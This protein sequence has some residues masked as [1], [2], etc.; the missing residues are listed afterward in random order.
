MFC[1]A[2][3]FGVV[4]SSSDSFLAIHLHLRHHEPVTHG[5]VVAAVISMWLL[6]VFLPLMIFWAGFNVFSLVVFLLGVVSVVCTPMVKIKIYLTVQ[7]HKNQIHVLQVQQEEQ[8][9]SQFCSSHKVG[10][11]CILRI[12]DINGIYLPYF[13]ILTV[14]ECNVSNV[15]LKRFSFF[16]LTLVHLNSSLNPVIYSAGRLDTFDT[17]SWTYCGKYLGSEI[18]NHIYLRAGSAMPSIPQIYCC[19]C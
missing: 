12:C 13:I 4:A 11:Q 17:L 2:L 6:N 1:I 10:S 9:G 15:A 3:F 19:Y 8:T 14:I 7:R 18:A 5:R 16:S